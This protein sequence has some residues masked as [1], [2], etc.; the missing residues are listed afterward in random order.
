MREER[1]SLSL[2]WLQTI[3]IN[4]QL[5]L[6]VLQLWFQIFWSALDIF[7]ALSWCTASASYLFLS[8][9]PRQ[10]A[11][12][13]ELHVRVML[14]TWAAVPGKSLCAHQNC[15][16]GAALPRV[17]K[18]PPAEGAAISAQMSPEFCDSV[19]TDS[20]GDLGSFLVG[21]ECPRGGWTILFNKR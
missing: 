1:F 13:S 8:L 21:S 19:K 2:E 10:R 5:F 6:F 14:R 18:Q 16:A 12:I 7:C 4:S 9:H 11:G 3:N 15:D 17:Q 20:A